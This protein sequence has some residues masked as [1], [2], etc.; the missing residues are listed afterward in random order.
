MKTIILDFVNVV[1]DLNLEKAFSELNIGQKFAALR[2]YLGSLRNGVIKHSL[3]EY[4]KGII[5]QNQLVNK[6]AITYPNIAK[7]IPYLLDTL[8]GNLVVNPEILEY[9]KAIKKKGAQVLIMSNSIPE[10]EEIMELYSLNDVFDDII[11][12]TKVNEI[13]PNKNIFEYAIK[14]YRLKPED[15]V[16][17]DDTKKNL[18][19]AEAFGI[20]GIH[21]SNTQET[22]EILD[23]YLVY[24]DMYKSNKDNFQQD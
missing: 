13:K 16:F 18:K 24:L 23:A 5:T 4:Q 6:L 19:G 10:T 11:L 3:E 14:H 7:Q 20:E 22:C 15:T 9:V 21:C 1:A 8:T 12:S 17:V 2:L